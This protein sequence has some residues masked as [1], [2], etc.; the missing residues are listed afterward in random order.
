MGGYT[1]FLP[2]FQGID[3]DHTFLPVRGG[4]IERRLPVGLLL[5]ANWLCQE[6]EWKNENSTGLENTIIV[7][8]L[9]CAAI[10]WFALFEA[11]G[12]ISSPLLGT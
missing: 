1:P 9:R 10:A 2:Q 5:S 8:L 3:S 6:N 12:L 7:S 11:S 4:S